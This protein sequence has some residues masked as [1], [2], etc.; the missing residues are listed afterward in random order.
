DDDLSSGL[1]ALLQQ[2]YRTETVEESLARLEQT[3]RQLRRGSRRRL[4]W[5]R[6]LVA[7][8][9]TVTVVATVLT[10]SRFHQDYSGGETIGRAKPLVTAE[11]Q[12]LPDQQIASRPD[13][14]TG[15]VTPT[16]IQR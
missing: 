3:W 15:G 11:P 10:A 9:A 6:S 12:S 16:L 1:A 4:I 13:A 7:A 5:Q 8:A 14:C 2:A